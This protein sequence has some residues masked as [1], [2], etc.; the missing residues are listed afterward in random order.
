M[1]R[2]A[3]LTWLVLCLM[4]AHASHDDGLSLAFDDAPVE[5]VLQAL[6]DYQHIN[7]MISPEVEGRLSLRL[8]NVPWQQALSLVGRMARLTLLEEENVLLV[9]P[10]SWQQQRHEAEKA[11]QAEAL[12]QQP[13]QQRRISLHYASASDVHRSLQSERPSLMTARGSATVD[14]RTNSL[15]LR[16]S[17]L[18]L[19]ETAR[20]IRALDVPLEQ[21][22]L[23]AHIVTI[24]EEHLHELGVNWRLYN[25]GDVINR[26]LR[27]PLLDIPLGLNSHDVS[28]GVTLS[29]IGGK[30]LDL[31][32]SALE[33]ENQVEIIASPRLFTSHQQTAS[34]KQGTE[35]PYE[36]SAG[37]SG[38]T[39]IEFKEAVL[40][41]EVTPAVLG[42][43]RI[44]LKIR[45]SQNVP[46]RAV[47]TGDSQVLSIDK[48]EIE[49]QVTVSDGQTL[50]LGGIF[51]QQRTRG[52][53]QVPL[54]GNLPVVGSLFRQH[55]EEQRK[56]E[57]VIFMTPRLVRE[58]ALSAR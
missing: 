13:L 55:A 54:L 29:R 43:G 23:A 45:I 7:L 40:G 5:R 16:D 49:T 30:L 12:Q 57:L 15:L 42:N 31:E 19:E 33:Q 17:P 58:A 56:R 47:Q 9:Y 6:A 2:T 14:S 32:L 25:E 48:Q 18:A 38:A 46:G 50:A 8:E 10:E 1:I 36:V 51:H 34:I 53:R 21:V 41:M 24:S 27:H 35:I 52:Q 20:W 44:Q 3:I 22:E 39:S 28:V 11:Q 4:P 26:A 37:N